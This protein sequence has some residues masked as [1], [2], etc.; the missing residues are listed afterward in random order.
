MPGFVLLVCF[1]CSTTQVRL[2]CVSRAHSER[3]SE[4]LLDFFVL[5]VVFLRGIFAIG[6]AMLRAPAT[7][8]V[9]WHRASDSAPKGC[10]LLFSFQ[11]LFYLL[12]SFC[13]CLVALKLRSLRFHSP[14]LCR[15]AVFLIQTNVSLPPFVSRRGLSNTNQR[16][17]P[18]MAYTVSS[19]Y[20]NEH[21][22]HLQARPLYIV[23]HVAHASVASVPRSCNSSPQ[24]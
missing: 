18:V 19:T 23:V 12:V 14:R 1:R 7:K 20:S 13:T 5:A 2:P 16:L 21:H 4:S 10:G 22:H 11:S 9:L 3:Q 8:L 17:S 24:H 15:A 6:R